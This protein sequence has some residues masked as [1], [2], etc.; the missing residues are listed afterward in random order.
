MNNVQGSGE[1]GAAALRAVHE[2][3]EPRSRSRF[4]GMLLSILSYRFAGDAQTAIESFELC[5]VST[6]ARSTHVV[7]E[8]DEA[9]R[10][11]ING[12]EEQALRG[13]LVMHSARLDSKEKL[14]QEVFDIA[15]AKSALGTASTSSP[16]EIDALRR[17]NKKEEKGRV[18]ITAR[19]KKGLSGIDA[20]KT[21]EDE[22]L[23]LREAGPQEV[24]VPEARNRQDQGDFGTKATQHQREESHKFRSSASCCTAGFNVDSVRTRSRRTVLHLDAG[25]ALNTHPRFGALGFRCST[26]CVPAKLRREQ[27]EAVLLGPEAAQCERG[28][29]G[30]LR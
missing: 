20:F 7:P 21:G 2:Q 24:G 10:I 25:A 19:G 18:K 17:D 11:V 27:C 15:R 9:G 5:F 13:H 29:R 22:I 4:A 14:K 16:M 30:A 23:L 12:M 28:R 26:L 3:W 6:K 8:F 1:G